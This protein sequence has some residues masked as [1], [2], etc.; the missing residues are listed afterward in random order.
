MTNE[1][2]MENLFSGC[3]SCLCIDDKN[4]EVGTRKSSNG[5][6]IDKSISIDSGS[7]HEDDVMSWTMH[8][9]CD[10]IPCRPRDISNN[11]SIL[12]NNTIE[13]A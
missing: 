9:V 12:T 1:L 4:D 13:K 10:K 6:I 3:P 5:F 7:I 11:C 2:G 8:F